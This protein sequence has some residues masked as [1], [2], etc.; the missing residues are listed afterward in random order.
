MVLEACGGSW[1]GNVEHFGRLEKELAI[2]SPYGFA[3]ICGNT[4]GKII[5]PP[6]AML[7]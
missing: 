2:G 4:Q 1:Q 3:F 7:S 5:F 6:P